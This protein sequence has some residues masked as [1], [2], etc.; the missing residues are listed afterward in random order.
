MRPMGSSENLVDVSLAELVR[1][2]A[3]RAPVP[4]SG[5][6]AAAVGALGAG[7]ASMALRSAREEP[8]SSESRAAELETTSARLLE[9]VDLDARAFDELRAATV[10]PRAGPEDGARERA[11]ERSVAVPLSTA[12]L[13]LSALRGL[14]AGAAGVRPALRSE[15][16]ASAHALVAALEG[17]GAVVEANLASFG[18]ERASARHRAALT[19]A[20][21][22]A[23][24][25]LE[26]VCAT[27]ARRRA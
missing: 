21:A 10:K 16:V 27:A 2:V 7:L 12:E 13:A 23:R 9:Q 22:E 1:R 4:G 20:R 24:E 3:A 26:R 11:L 5:S 6:V 8:E 25:L 14:G 17:S 18:D 15:C 19:A